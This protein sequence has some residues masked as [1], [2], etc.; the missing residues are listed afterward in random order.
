VCVCVCDS[1]CV[2]VFASGC[3]VRKIKNKLKKNVS[4]NSVLTNTKIPKIEGNREAKFTSRLDE[5]GDF[6][7]GVSESVE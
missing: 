5:I 2:C 3:V 1:V 4:Y 7:F 6:F